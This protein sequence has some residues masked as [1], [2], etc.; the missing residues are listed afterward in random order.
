MLM[1]AMETYHLTLLT[2]GLLILNQLLQLQNSEAQ[3]ILLS[4]LLLP[5]TALILKTYPMAQPL[6]QTLLETLP[7][8]LN[9]KSSQEISLM[10]L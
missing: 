4:S 7:Q 9:K 5:Q 1:Q 2:L 8:F 6:A 10:F 3:K